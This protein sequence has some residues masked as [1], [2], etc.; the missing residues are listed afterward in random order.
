MHQFMPI[1]NWRDRSMVR[2]GYADMLLGI[3]CFEL[4]GEFW[5]LPYHLVDTVRVHLNWLNLMLMLA[6]NLSNSYDDTYMDFPSISSTSHGSFCC[7]SNWCY[8]ELCSRCPD[9]LR[10]HH[11]RSSLHSRNRLPR[12][13]DDLQCF[14]LPAHDT[15]ATSRDHKTWHGKNLWN[16]VHQYT[17]FFSLFPWDLVALQWQVLFI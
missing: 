4:L 16:L 7:E 6:Q 9:Q 1:W 11:L 3:C 17:Y 13:L 10:C 5:A 15:E 2:E 14:H 12:K 8:A